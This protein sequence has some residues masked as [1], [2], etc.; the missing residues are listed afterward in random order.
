MVFSYFQVI[1]IALKEIYAILIDMDKTAIAKVQE[2]LALVRSQISA[3]KTRLIE[4]EAEATRLAITVDVLQQLGGHNVK[5][6]AADAESAGGIEMLAGL[7]SGAFSS[8]AGGAIA[9][10]FKRTTRQLILEQ[11]LTGE[12]LTRI[13]VVERVKAIDGD[14]N[15]QT[16][17]TTLSKMTAEAIL[18]K[19]EGNA[20]RLKVVPGAENTGDTDDLLKT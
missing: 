12:A 8:S 15:E 16:I 6:S 10:L 4:L 3:T 17:A 19:A 2:K 20:Y 7:L 1:P 11:F 5:R 14:V 9:G 13:Q 18:E